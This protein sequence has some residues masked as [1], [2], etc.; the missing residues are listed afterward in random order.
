MAH[1]WIIKNNLA[2]QG[3]QSAED[4]AHFEQKVG[5]RII[6]KD[7]KELFIDAN[8]ANAEMEWEREIWDAEDNE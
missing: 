6:M 5:R 4:V 8:I 2:S 7:G 3:G 1:F